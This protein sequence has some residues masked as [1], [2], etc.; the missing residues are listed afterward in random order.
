MTGTSLYHKVLI[1]GGGSAGISVA[2]RLRRA[3]VTDIGMIEPSDK[4][5]YQ[6]LWTL[7]GGGCAPA[8]ES[9]RSEAAVMPKGVVWIKDAAESIDPETQ[10]VSTASGACGLRPSGGLPWHPAGLG[11]RARN[12]RRP[13]HGGRVE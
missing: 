9:E 12:G 4:H 13:V 11:T 10:T 6:P 1:V 8:A 3:K 7:V 2:A 5:Y